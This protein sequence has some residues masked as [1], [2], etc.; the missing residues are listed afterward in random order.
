MREPDA[1]LHRQKERCAGS[2][3]Q[4]TRTGQVVGVDV[5]IQ[6]V[7]DSPSALGC[8]LEVDVRIERS[9]DDER[10]RTGSDEI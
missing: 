3:A 5:S 6:N 4:E 10:F 2:L 9:L 8:E 7:S 1:V